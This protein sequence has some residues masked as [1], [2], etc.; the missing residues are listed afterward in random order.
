MTPATDYR[1]FGGYRLFL[2]WLVMTSHSSNHLPDWVVPLALGNVGV[3]AF[4]VLSGFV[5]AEACDRFYAGA[6]QRFLANR[7]L[8]IYPTYWVACLLALAVYV[9]LGHPELRLDAASIAGNLAILHAQPGTFFWLSLIW[10][11][12]I[13]L[14]FY[15]VAAAMLAAQA[16]LRLPARAVFAAAALVALALYAVTV[17]SDYTRLATFRHAPYFMLGMAGYYAITRASVAGA[18]LAAISAPVAVHA[19]YTY[20]LPG[21]APLLTT[22]LF[23]LAL[24][25][26]GG[27]AYARVSPPTARVDKVLGDLTYPLYLVH[28][29]MVYFV[30]TK[31]PGHGLAG[32]AAISLASFL[33]AAA[34]LL[35]EQPITRLRDRVRRKRLYE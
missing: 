30:D 34:I 24:A 35:L 31:L 21:S 25:A 23:I 8:R 1:F 7:L 6:P 14:R 16:W 33:A 3:F 13:E 28:W 11:V 29:P 26:M 22:V 9:P 12:G 10:A 32:Y 17:A 4:F 20:N 5:I 18:V 2:A 15:F 27:L 19:Y